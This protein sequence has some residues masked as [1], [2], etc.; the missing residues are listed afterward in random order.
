LKVVPIFFPNAGCQYRC[1]F[2]N[3]WM[4]TMK[5]FP[6]SVTDEIYKAYKFYHG[7]ENSELALYGGT[8]TAIENWRDILEKSHKCVKKLGMRGI[9]LSTRPDEIKDVDFLKANGVVSVEIGAQSMC[10][11]V[12]NA[13]R[14]RHTAEDVQK[15]VKMLKNAGIK[16]SVHLMTALPK[17]TKSKSLFSSFEVASL[18]PNGVRIHPTLVL[19]NTELEQKYLNGY[20]VPQSLKEAL[21]WVSDMIAVFLN[22]KILIE[23]IGMYQDA[24]TLKNVVGGPFHPAFGEMARSM[25]YRKY[26]ILTEAKR[27][28]GPPRLR[29][30][31][32]GRNRDLELEFLPSDRIIVEGKAG[33][34]AFDEWLLKY[35]HSLKEM[36]RCD[37]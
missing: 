29:S 27:V 4:A 33:K 37:L 6:K 11:D 28:F 35:V 9:R 5:S 20:Y 12:L 32:I 25:L 23:R 1:V 3:E 10:Q 14:R 30:Q 21:D 15:A 8:F 13:S 19:K 31:I 18:M 7:D 26:L 2:C 24:E 17:D 16:V 36:A 34:I 22:G